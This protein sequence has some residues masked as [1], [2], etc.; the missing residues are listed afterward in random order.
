MRWL[1]AWLMMTGG[2]TTWD[3][4]VSPGPAA[5]FVDGEQSDP[6]P[7]DITR[8]VPVEVMV[9]KPGYEP[10]IVAPGVS[11]LT[12]SPVRLPPP[13][14]LPLRVR[15]EARRLLRA[16]MKAAAT[17]DCAE[18]RELGAQMLAIDEALHRRVFS[19]ERTIQPCLATPAPTTPTP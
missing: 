3:V 17:N 6:T 4:D 14:T 12:L 19:R 18:V 7:N 11:R 9:W 13:N 10:V 16:A 5:V 8:I 1:V 15:V 2:C